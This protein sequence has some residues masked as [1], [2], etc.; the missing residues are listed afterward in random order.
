MKM[1]YF[2]QS[3]LEKEL[4]LHCMSRG[5]QHLLDW[6]AYVVKEPIIAITVFTNSALR[7]R[8]LRQSSTFRVAY[9]LKFM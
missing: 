3:S 4:I 5:V 1:D 8:E 9:S 6:I 7:G 2:S